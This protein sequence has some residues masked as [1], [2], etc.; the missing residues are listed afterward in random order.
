MSPF[1]ILFLAVDAVITVSVLLFVLRRRSSGS[2]ATDAFGA[3]RTTEAPRPPAASGS[4]ARL[5]GGG[6]LRGLA[7]FAAEQD[8]RI[9]DYVRGN[10][11]GIPE[12]LP[13]VLGALLGELERDAQ[14]KGLS[15]DRETLKSMLAGSLRSHRI[16]G[17][18]D[19]LEA[20]EKVS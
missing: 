17:G 2:G 19:V 15:F 11:S 6:Q 10:W 4:F 7:A 14:A 8:Q 20:L 9:W 3:P 13:A 1:L 5:F 18:A 16:G 12:Q